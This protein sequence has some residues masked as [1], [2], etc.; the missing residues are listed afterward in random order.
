LL[1]AG[2]ATREAASTVTCKFVEDRF[3]P[4]EPAAGGSVAI[5]IF[6]L[7]MGRADQGIGETD[8][9]ATHATGSHSHSHW[10]QRREAYEA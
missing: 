10:A 1:S 3:L 8:F 5:C 4:T 2:V 6:A 7:A 9:T